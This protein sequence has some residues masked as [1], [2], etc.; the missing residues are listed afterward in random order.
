MEGNRRSDGGEFV[1]QRRGGF[2]LVEVVIAASVL[3]IALFGILSMA[4]HTYRKS[5]V[6][7][8]A[9][10]AAN[11]AT[12]RLS[13]FRSHSNPF[14]A[15]G[16]TFYAPPRARNEIDLNQDRGNNRS[17]LHN[18]WNAA[19]RLFV[20]EYLFATSESR[21]RNR[22]LNT[23][24]GRDAQR[25]RHAQ[26]D[27]TV[28]AEAAGRRNYIADTPM[29]T[30]I[31]GV[32][33][34]WGDTAGPPANEVVNYSNRLDGSGAT[35]YTFVP[36]PR[37]NDDLRGL[38]LNQVPSAVRYIREVWVQTNSPLGTP[39]NAGGDE[40]VSGL[41]LT[42]PAF[43]L[44][45]AGT[46]V[47]NNQIRRGANA[48]AGAGS[49]VNQIRMPPW[50]ITVTVRVFARDNLVRNFLNNGA[51]GRARG[52]TGFEGLGY[53]PERPLATAVGYFGV[54]HTLGN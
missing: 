11:L 38:P 51:V 28:A 16:G 53:D 48:S 1:T 23:D 26:S 2:T 37:A 46:A 25:A 7:D 32:F 6:A 41:G 17:R 31:D 14:K 15:A 19:P 44:S 9:I 4:F 34:N 21:F 45:P 42:A 50:V 18:I 49:G 43:Y 29:T 10:T 40:V 52:G 27:P 39:Y 20:R 22:A 47:I 8:E 35:N 3:V 24:E 36:A 33:P 30:A 54:R 12:E 5:D 13:Y